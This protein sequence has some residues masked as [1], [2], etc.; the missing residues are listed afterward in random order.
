MG[1][2][3]RRE[4]D[5]N[6]ERVETESEYEEDQETPTA[7]I[8]KQRI[9]AI[10]Q[11]DQEMASFLND[12]PTFEVKFTPPE[13]LR[14]SSIGKGVNLSYVLQWERHGENYFLADKELEA[15][16]VNDDPD[17]TKTLLIKSDC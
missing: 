5:F 15:L 10:Q 2:S 12:A 6:G 16:Y 9:E 1:P 14:L 13:L 11:A 3:T 8:Q 4:H 7:V 17:P